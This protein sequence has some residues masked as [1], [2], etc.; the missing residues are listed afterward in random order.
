[1]ASPYFDNPTAM[2]QSPSAH[3]DTIP[4]A[5]TES[6]AESITQST[7]DSGESFISQVRGNTT[8]IS[9]NHL[10]QL[11]DQAEA[12]FPITAFQNAP[13]FNNSMFLDPVLAF[14]I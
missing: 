14:L 13:G 5:S 12:R 11:P 7:T 6:T 3:A 4:M 8:S 2:P 10:A 1:M 9:S